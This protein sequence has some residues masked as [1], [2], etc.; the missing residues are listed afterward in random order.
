MKTLTARWCLA[1]AATACAACIAVAAAPRFDSDRAWEDL[2]QLVAIGPRPAGS[3]AI[4]QA[5][6]YIGRQLA[7]A[8]L[9]AHE[10]AWD[11]M[12]PIGR[13]HMVNLIATLPGASKDRIIVAGH[14]DTK[15]FRE[16]RFVGAS[17][18]GSSAAF[19][20]ELARALAGQKHR[21]TIELLFLDGEEAVIDWSD[22][23][24][25]YGSR[26][27]VQTAKRDGSLA[28][29]KA[30]VLIDMVGDRDLQ[31]RRDLN[32]TPWL[33]DIVWS[34]AK[35]EKLGAY[36]IP[37]TTRV[38]DDHDEFTAAGVPAVDIIDLDY[39]PWHTAADNLDA[40]SARSLQIVGD[41]VL[42]ALPQIEAHFK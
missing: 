18:G 12:T 39:Q 40:V 30:L 13:V 10:Q 33:T 20:L 26:H 21:Y 36:F 4:E 35:R 19:L 27:Y 28:G 29:I 11:Q 25:T 32:S 17:D 34:A 8:G 7:A 38:E 22:H 3:A 15:L 23:D 1:A 14:Y 5:R 31:I 42:A 24:H 2:R 6:T 9:Q 16:F 41:V 37:D